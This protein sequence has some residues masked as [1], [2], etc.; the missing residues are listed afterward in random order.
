MN[1]RY[2]AY[3]TAHGCT[4]EEMRAVDEERFPGGRTAGF[5]IWMSQRWQE[6]A[7]LRGYRLPASGQ[8]T[9]L[10]D[11]DYADFDAWLAGIAAPFAARAA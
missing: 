11:A 8:R 4:P 6:W 9:V 5:L 2:V 10:S 1:P 3:A 7:K